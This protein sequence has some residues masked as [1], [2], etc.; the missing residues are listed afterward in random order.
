MKHVRFLPVLYPLG[1]INVSSQPM[2]EQS[3]DDLMKALTPFLT[4]FDL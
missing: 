2:I 4:E 3:R 1:T